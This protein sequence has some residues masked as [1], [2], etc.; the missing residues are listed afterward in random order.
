MGAVSAGDVLDVCHPS[1][2]LQLQGLL[3][4]AASLLKFQLLASPLPSLAAFGVLD[5]VHTP[6]PSSQAG[7]SCSERLV[8]GHAEL[9]APSLERT[10]IFLLSNGSSS[11]VQPEAPLAAK[12]SCPLVSPGGSGPRCSQLQHFSPLGSVYFPRELGMEFSP[13]SFWPV[14]ALP[15]PHF[16]LQ[17]W[18][19]LSQGCLELGGGGQEHPLA[20]HSWCPILVPQP[21]QAWICEGFT[22]GWQSAHVWF[23]PVLCLLWMRCPQPLTFAKCLVVIA[24]HARSNSGSS[25]ERQ[26]GTGALRVKEPLDRSVFGSPAHH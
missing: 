22:A 1:V 4:G 5:F 9:S 23:F 11:S 17:Q 10:L 16:P 8:Q 13:T 12:C 14:L 21:V 15:K 26:A 3:H 25:Q 24:L 20:S 19:L 7:R 18:V 2:L 6:A